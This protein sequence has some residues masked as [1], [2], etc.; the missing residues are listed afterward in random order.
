MDSV[1]AAHVGEEV[2]FDFVLTDATGAF[3]APTGVADYVIATIGG[4]RQAVETDLGGHFVFSHHFKASKPGDRVR[5][6]T[7]AFRERGR[8]D[9]IQVLGEVPGRA[10]AVG[11]WIASESSRD[12]PDQ[13]IASDAVDLEFYQAVVD[14]PVSGTGDDLDLDTGVMRFRKLDGRVVAVYAMRP[15]R[16]GFV[17]SERSAAGGFRVTFQPDASMLNPSGSTEVEFSIQDRAGRRVTA[18]ATLPTP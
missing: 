8:R 15:G 6:T 11:R 9:F 4:Q 2:A 1:Q 7:E 3:L 13:R 17:L 14:L 10:Q 16:P 18:S 12:E 5:V